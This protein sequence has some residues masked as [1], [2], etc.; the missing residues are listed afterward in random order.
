[1][2]ILHTRLFAIPDEPRRWY[3]VI[4]WWEL[5][6]IPYNIV[7]IVVGTIGLLIFG[8]I[9]SFYSRA[10]PEHDDWVPLLSAMVGFFG[11]NFFYTTGWISELFA[12]ALWHE[13]A[14]YYGPIM[15]SVGL[16]FSCVVCFVPS[17]LLGISWTYTIW[18]FRAH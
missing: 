11:A 14:R 18:Q 9:Y 5:R 6:R 13:R 12:R 1:M 10:Q 16:L 17:I 2:K 15:L 8:V 4:A 7:V 3:S